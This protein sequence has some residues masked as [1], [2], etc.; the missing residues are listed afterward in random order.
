V[1]DIFISIKEV[2]LRFFKELFT[3]GPISFK[4]FFIEFENSFYCRMRFCSAVMVTRN[5]LSE[6]CKEIQLLERSIRFVGI[7]NK[8]GTLIATS[9]RDGLIPLMNERET[10]HY[11]VQ[12]VLRAAIRED[13]ESKIGKLEYSVGKYQKLIRAT[14]PIRFIEDNEA[15]FYLLLSFDADSSAVFGVIERK[16]LPLIATKGS[17]FKMA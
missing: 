1:K 3:S 6:I 10:S 9:Y 12:A 17:Y 7:A 11:A 5:S 13:F 2:T 15:K 4:E 8:R 14:I 16:I